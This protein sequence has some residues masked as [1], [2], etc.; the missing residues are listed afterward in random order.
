ML[1]TPA[2]K[3]LRREIRALLTVGT[4]GAAAFAAPAGA[5]TSG[6]STTPELQ[7]IVVTGSLIKRTDTETPSPVQVITADD[8]KNSGYT[9]VSDVL[10][11]L[12]ANGS[13]TLNQGFG[14]AFAAG[15]TGIALRGLSVGDTLT[16]ID[17]QRMV[18]YPLSDDG[19]RSFVDVTAIP[20]NA[21]EGID[22]VKDGASA[23]YGADAIA[24]VVNVKLKKS[25]VGSEFTAEAGS[26]QFGDGTTEHMSGIWGMGDLAS[27]G[28]NVYVALDWHHQDKIL[29]ANRDGAFTTTNW[30][31]LPGGNNTQPGAVG[32]SSLVYPD[33][34]SGY[35]VNPTTGA[36]SGYLPGCDAA[37]QA[38]NKCTFAFPG[39]IQSPTTQINLLSKFTK[40]LANDWSLTVTGSVFDSS[41]QQIAATTFGHAF[42]NTGQEQGSIVNITFAPGQLAGTVVYPVLSLPA[43][44]PLN[45]TGATQNLVYSFPDVGPYQ[46]DVD[47]LTYRL[48]GD[49]NGKLGG[50][51]IH[52]DVGIMYSSMTEKI[53]GELI[54]SLAQTAL[55]DG[56]Y[57]PGVS[58][59]GQALFAPPDSTHPSSTLDVVDLSA[60]RDL[61][62]M[63]GGPLT[64]AVGGQYIH[65][66][67]NVED[68]PPVVSGY[69]EG[70][71]FFSQ[72]SQD[73][74]AGFVEF[75]GKPIKQL[76]VDLSGR[77]DH[78]DTY[79]GSATPRIGVKFTPI[80]QFAIRG[81]WGKGF[82]APSIAESG[83]AGLAF[84]QGNVND[85]VLCPGGKANVA[86]TFNALCSYP[87]VGVAASN[88]DL[89]A[90]TSTN[91]TFGVIFEPTKAF[92]VSVDWYHIELKNDIISASSAGGFY[93]DSI[94]L[95][96]GPSATLAQCTATTT[97]GVP[98]PT[99]NVPTPVGYP[100]YTLVPYVNAG[101]TK[102]SGF[103]MDMKSKFDLGDFGR[104]KTEINYTYISQ[105]ELVANGTI[106][107]LA[108]THGP[109]SIS[110]DTGNPRSRAVASV[111]WEQGAFTSTLSVNY[112]SSFSIVDPSSGYN[113]CLQALQG[114]SPSAYG[115]ALNSGVTTLPSQWYQYCSVKHF[116]DVNLY[117][118]YAATDHLSVHGSITNL[119]GTQP[120]VDLQTYGGGAELAYS[121][122]DQDGAVGRFFL[123]GATYKF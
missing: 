10:R 94:E 119:F 42:S 77:Y 106:F 109:Q 104:L 40:S 79:G 38:A 87:A 89:K 58:T 17:G 69:Q 97:G 31:A 113:T 80:D 76:E 65:K 110:G 21:V 16:L 85:P 26:T 9:N 73:D 98:C 64:M 122:L 33:S 95:V 62:D 91:A 48:F 75:G 46:V 8:L 32:A 107:D 39:T 7:E 123:V 52:G 47:T 30:S 82:R 81:T 99:Q 36:V 115:S 102:T 51:D 114:R 60:Q 53:F 54:P 100:S 83:T 72:G 1:F 59:N 2:A 55:N 14:Q 120:P 117:A 15:A 108:G 41:A 57:V 44:S 121:T 20:I 22:V 67:L 105:Y 35:L 63:P 19:E 88:P 61:F 12:S 101:S 96:R 93:V 70:T 116:T 111:T 50:W 78:Y 112:Q 103:D 92:N 86:G 23:L 11:T 37:S 45:K 28:Y 68:P 34:V 90:V 29:G 43:T 13:G 84:G 49:V 25:Y 56:T 74:A 4:I 71:I 66:A 18:S 5:Q 24:G 3:S 6:V 118:A 27:D